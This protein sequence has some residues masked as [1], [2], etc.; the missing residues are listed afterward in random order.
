[1]ES[2]FTALKKYS[3]NSAMTTSARKFMMISRIVK[4]VRRAAKLT[5]STMITLKACRKPQ[6]HAIKK[7]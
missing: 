3:S 4:L 1:M 2:L 6:S 5:D 7:F